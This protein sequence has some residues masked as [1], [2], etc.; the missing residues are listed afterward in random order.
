M[1]SWTAISTSVDRSRREFQDFEFVGKLLDF[2]FRPAATRE[3]ESLL[4]DVCN[5]KLTLIVPFIPGITKWFLLK[6]PGF[7]FHGL[8]P[9]NFLTNRP[10]GLFVFSTEPTGKTSR[11]VNLSRECVSNEFLVTEIY[12]FTINDHHK[13]YHRK[14]NQKSSKN[15][16]SHRICDPPSRHCQV[17]PPFR[18]RLACSWSP[19]FWRW[20]EVPVL[21][22]NELQWSLFG[23]WVFWVFLCSGETKNCVPKLVFST[24]KIDGYW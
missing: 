8:K 15:N 9:L 7:V 18:G 14:P 1:R 6:I 21:R 12:F 20:N 24:R 16:I 11:I 4:V 17:Q 10:K 23:V 22:W 19:I 2:D 3:K 5:E 13:T